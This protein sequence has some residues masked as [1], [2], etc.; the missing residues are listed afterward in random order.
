MARLLRLIPLLAAFLAADARA[1]TNEITLTIS[2]HK[3]RAE[4]AASPDARSQGLMF[5]ER[6]E[7]NRGMLF[8]F[9]EATT[10]SMWMMNTL[11][12]LSVAFLGPDGRILNIRDM[13]PQTLDM[14]ASE[15]PAAYALETNRG[16]FAERGIR[17]GMRVEGL[18]SAPRP[19]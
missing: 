14:H 17:A 16:W 4:I 8:V 18:E 5:R 10:Q 3:L 15:G 9:P 12:P 7:P 2:G 13:A 11:I 6:L 1:Q 19:Q